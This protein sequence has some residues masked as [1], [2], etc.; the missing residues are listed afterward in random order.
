[1]SLLSVGDL[2]QTTPTPQQ[3]LDR[4]EALVAAALC[5]GLPDLAKREW[6]ADYRMRNVQRGLGVPL[7]GKR[8]LGPEVLR[9][10]P[11]TGLG[12]VTMDGVDRT[13]ECI[14][15]A[16]SVRLDALASEFTPLSVVTVA[17]STGWTAQEL[18]NALRQAIV[19]TAEGLTA[20]PVGI[21]AERLGDVETQ[22][23]LPNAD[24]L[25]PGVLSLLAPWR[26]VGV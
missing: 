10:W 19:L 6:V 25:P 4:A 18:P 9:Y 17:F 2:V 14:F 22:Y 7:Y 3:A 26:H 11:V 13:A 15:D 20:Q 23:A 16:L 8:R 1:M 24:A 21:K 5:P 12:S